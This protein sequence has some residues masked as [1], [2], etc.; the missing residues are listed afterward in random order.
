MAT[1]R[2]R[3]GWRALESLFDAGALGGLTDGELLECFQASR[4]T[5]GHDAFRVLVERHGPMV[6]GMCRSLVRDPH[7]ADD[8][9][10]A[11]FLVLVRKAGSIERRDTIGPWLH[12]VAGRVA[13][14]ARDRAVRRRRR[15][16]E[17]NEEI[18]CPVRPIVESPSVEA[19]V[20][21][22]IA[23][24]PERFRAPV[25]LCCL[26]GLSYDLAARRLGVT[27]PTL[28]GRLH[29]ARKQL[30]SR[31]RGRG[32]TAG[33]FT[34]AVE[35]V[36][37]TLTPLPSSLLESTVQF[38]VRWSSV[39]GLLAGAGII[40]ES[41]AGL[42][43]GV[44]KSMVLQSLKLSGIAV[45]TAAAALGTV[46]VAQQGKNHGVDGGAQTTAPPT[47][48]AQEK[49][50]ARTEDQA[51]RARFRARLVELQQAIKKV[52][53]LDSI[54]AEQ[55]RIHAELQRAENR[56][57]ELDLKEKT[58][59]VEK[60]LDLRIDAEFPKGIAL[61]DLLKHIKKETTKAQPPGLPIYVNPIGLEE[62][63]RVMGFIVTVNHKQQPVRDI[64]QQA[65]GD[66]GLK[67][68]ATDGFLMIDSRTGILEIHVKEID[69]KLG[70]VLEALDRLEKAK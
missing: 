10:Q 51:E 23:R 6:L 61:V 21:D 30:A 53:E 31:L 5:V 15:E 56:A 65:L 26:E 67:F 70:Q 33:M 4:D 48:I 60:Q 8:A 14:R 11:T 42:A 36:R 46:V 22:E 17:A 41:I 25:V 9:F 54:N 19:V 43:Q 13:R 32:I 18:P 12:G 44:I 47:A 63:K 38:S 69:R 2:T 28:R 1:N 62:L 29:R 59:Q 64:L 57:R 7:E 52:R 49:P 35:P 24:L 50:D 34:S 39:T 68:A 45:L 37:L 3:P 20:Q 27:E 66:A 55:M 40:P 16:V 58:K